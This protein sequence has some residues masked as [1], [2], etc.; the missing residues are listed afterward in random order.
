MIAKL[1]GILDEL[2][3]NRAVVDVNGVGYLVHASV[4]TMRTMPPL[5]SEVTLYIESHIREDR[6]DLFA[7]ATKEERAA[8][9][10][11]VGVQNVGAKVALSVLSIMSPTDLALAVASGDVAAITQANGVGK[12]TA[13]RVVLELKDKMGSLPSG[14]GSVLSG[15]SGSMD[16][17]ALPLRDA[18]S[19]LVNLGYR[20]MEAE[21]AVTLAAADLGRDAAVE[22]LIGHS[23]KELGR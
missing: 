5:G 21:R 10:L 15:A 14:V 11:L 16:G 20:A 4:T 3:E 17:E 8:Y 2:G 6:F 22:A 18:V 12:K 19:A 23:L 9:R 13:E 1:R 7:F